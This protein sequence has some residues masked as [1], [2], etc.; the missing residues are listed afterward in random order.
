MKRLVIIP[1]IVGSTL[2][3]AGSAIFAIGLTSCSKKDTLTHE[4]AL[5]GDI[6][7]I[8][9][10]V[11]VSDVIFNATTDGTKKV[12][13]KESEK[14]YHTYSVSEGKLQIGFKDERK[15]HDKMFTMNH[16][17]VE[18]YLPAAHY[19]DLVAKDSTGDFSIP[20]DFSFNSINI[21]ASTGDMDLKCSVSENINIKTSTGHQSLSSLSAKNM[22]LNADTG[23]LTLNSVTV[24]EKLTI[25]RSTGSINATNVR[26]KD[27][28][29]KSSTGNVTLK[30]VVIDNH[31]QIETSTGNVK[32]DDSDATTLSIK[33]STGD[34]KGT[35]LTKKIFYVKTD[36]GKV[37]VPTSTEGGLCEITTDTG[38]ISISIK[39]Q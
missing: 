30:D 14:M 24:E 21:N 36:T 3:L 18:L 29:S 37:N 31:I 22:T 32:F 13:F 39:T 2:L 6:T 7:N 25:T 4:N 19:G 28:E 11:D 34:V 33:T 1:V 38:D 15:W 23:N 5:E 20:S 17:K 26:A 27:Y 8:D 16:F 35:L 12:V 9:I 10:N